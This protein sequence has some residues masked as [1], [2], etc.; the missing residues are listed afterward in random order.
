MSQ[1]DPKELR[2]TLVRA[3]REIERLRKQVAALESAGVPIAIVGVGLRLPGGICDLTGLWRALEAQLDAIGPIPADRWKLDDFYDPDTE[4]A[5]KSY[6]REGGFVTNIDR[7]DP[8]FFGISP[9]EAKSIDPQHRLLLETAWEALEHAGIVPGSLAGTRTGVFVGIG[10]SDYGSLMRDAV[11]GDGYAIMGSHVSFAP[12]RIAFHLGLQGPSIALD[13]ACSSSLVALHLACASLRARESTIA[14]A[15]GA[16]A[17]TDPHTFVQLSRT[18]ALA[19]DGRS[20][21]FSDRADGYGRG[22]GAIVL[23]LERLSDAVASGREVLAVIRGSAVNHDG[24]SSGLTAPNGLAQQAVIRAA[25]SDANLEPN[26]IDYVEC[27]GTGTILGDPIE[28]GALAAVHAKGRTND[29]PLLLGTV[30]SNLGHLE[31]AS[32]LA[33]VAKLI[34]CLRHAKLPASLHALPLNR[35]IEWESLPLAVVTESVSWSAQAQ[36]PRRAAVSS[37]GLSGTNAHVILEG[38]PPPPAPRAR[39]HAVASP[40]PLLLSA[41]SQPALRH[42]AQ[43]LLAH[44][45]AERA[46][47]ALGD[48]AYSLATTR[49]HLEHRV[50]FVSADLEGALATLESIAADGGSRAPI[51]DR[52]RARPL[53]A[54]MFTGQGSQLH[55][56]GGALIDAY[57]VFRDAFEACAKLFDAQLEHDLRAVVRGDEPHAELL[58][59]TAYTQPALFAL[60]VA[61]F[62]LFESWGLTPDLVLGHSIGELAAAHVAGVVSLEHACALVAARG[63]L[64]QALPSGGVMI[65]IEAS[66]A[67]VR[68]QLGRRPGAVDIAGIN[69]P[70]STV[71]AGDDAAARAVAAEFEQLGRA[72]KH[73]TVS[74]AFHSQHMDAML[75]PLEAVAAGL[76]LRPPTLELVSNVTGRLATP[77]QLSSAKYW[78]DHARREVR[79]FDAIRTLETLGTTVVLELGPRGVLTS[80]A[81]GCL[82]PDAAKPM[83]LIASLRGDRPAIE[84]LASSVAELHCHGIALNWS[85]Y[86]EGRGCRRVP[87]P[88]YA[89]ARE[90]HWLDARPPRAGVGSSGRHPLSG[91]RVELPDDGAIHNVELGPAVQRYLADH[92]VFETI[93]V[94][95]AFYLAIMLA[96]GESCWPGRAIELR[97]VEFVRALGFEG[98][99]DRVSLHVRLTPVERDQLAASL[100]SR[101]SE[102]VWTTHANAILRAIEP[103]QLEPSLDL[104]SLEWSA[105]QADFAQMLQTMQIDWGPSWWWLTQTSATTDATVVGRLVAPDQAQIQDA[106]IPGGL[107]DN[108]FALVFWTPGFVYD[109]TPRLPFAVRRMVWSG[110]PTQPHYA[111]LT[112]VENALEQTTSNIGLFDDRGRPLAV[113]EGFVTRSAPPERFLARRP[114][115]DLYTVDHERVAAPGPRAATWT[116]LGAPI[117]GLPGPAAQFDDV[118]ALQLAR[119][120]AGLELGLTLSL[121]DPNATALELTLTTL[122]MLRTW[123]RSTQLAGHRL[124]VIT[125]QAIAA[126]PGDPVEHPAQAS[127][128][129][130]LRTAQTEHPEF[131]LTVVDVDEDPRST[132]ALLSVPDRPQ[133][134]I[135]GGEYLEPKLAAASLGREPLANPLSALAG[136]VLITGVTGALGSIVARHLVHEHGVRHLLGLSRAGARSPGAT[137]LCTELALAGA[138][139]RI[140]ACDVGDR[141]ALE[142]ALATVAP[143]QPLVAVMHIAGALD[144]A[145]IEDLRVEQVERVFAAK[146]DGARHLDE[147]TRA[148]PL[149]AF[150][151]FSSYSGIIGT[152]GQANYAAANTYLDS[153]AAQRR[154]LGL[155]ATSLAWGPWAEGGMAAR[156]GE[157]DRG[158]MRRQGVE[159]FSSADALALLDAAVRHDASVCVP[160]RLDLAALAAA[161][162]EP[163]S[164]LRGL[165]PRPPTSSS[166]A[167][168]LPA[169]LAQLD[170]TR[171]DAATLALVLDATVAVLGLAGASELDPEQPLSELGLDSLMAIELRNRLQRATQLRLPSTLLFDH[172]TPASLRDRLLTE[173]SEVAA[174]VPAAAARSSTQR[175]HTDDDDAIAIVGMACRFPG[176]VQDPE[177]LW[178]LLQDG[179]NATGPMPSNR[180]WD[181][182]ALH[183]PDPR[184]PGKSVTQRGGFLHDAADFDPLFF[185]ISPREAE[186]IDPQQRLLLETSW[187]AMEDA[188]IRPAKLRGSNTGVFV[189]IMYNDYGGRFINDPAALTG[190]VA[191]GSAASVAS[192]RLA[193]VFGLEGPALAVDTACS[194]SLVSTHLAARALRE[195]ECDLALASGVAVMATPGSF[196]EFSRQGAL[197]RDGRCKAFGAAADGVGWAEGAGVLILE[198]LADARANGHTVH[199]IIRGSAINQDGRSQGLTAPNGPAQQRVIEA[200][201]AAAQLSPLDVDA[202]EAHGTGTVLGDPI[203]AQALQ[204]V[205]GRGRPSDAPLWLGSIKSNLGHTQAAAGIAGIIKIVLAMRHQQLPRTLF[206]APA[207][208]HVDWSSSLALLHEPRP[209]T[210]EGRPRRAAVSSFGISGTNAHVILE[211]VDAPVA[212]EAPS[213]APSVVVISGKTDRA[214]RAQARSLRR[215][216]ERHEAASLT[217]MASGLAIARTQF[218][219]RAAFVATTRERALS[220]LE[221]L[222]DDRPD[223]T[224]ALGVVAHRPTLAFMFTGQGAQWLGMG[225]EL[226]ERQPVYRAAF[227]QVAAHLDPQLERPL[228]SIVFAEPGSATAAYLDQTRFTQPALFAVEVALYRLLESWGIT[229]Q[230]VIGH[231]I[232]EL[233]AAHVAG[234]L[235]LAHACQLVAARGRSMQALPTGGAMV[236]IAASESEV[237]AEI[238]RQLATVDIAGING[239]AS[240]VVSGPAQATSAIAEHFEALG[241]RVRRLEVSHAFHSR[242]MDP[243]LD[244]FRRVAESI[245]YAAPQLAVISSLTGALADPDQ[246]RDPAYWVRQVRDPVRFHDGV[247]A[248]AHEGANV[249]LEIGPH[250]V[251]S[252]MARDCLAADSPVSVTASLRRDRS[253]AKCLAETLAQLHCRGVEVDWLPY[254]GR[255]QARL[256]APLPTYAFQR[257]RYWMSPPPPP[258][259]EPAAG[260]LERSLWSEIERGDVGRLAKLAGVEP[261]VID[262]SWLAAMHR[263]RAHAERR[264]TLDSWRYVERWIPARDHVGPNAPAACV[265]IIPTGLELELPVGARTLTLERTSSREQ[266]ATQLRELAAQRPIDNWVS[267]LALDSTPSDHHCALTLTLMHAL[268]DL[269]DAPETASAKLC[270][271]T[272]GAVS[273]RPTD[274]PVDPTQSMIW[275]LSR[276]FALEYPGRWGGLVD[277]PLEPSHEDARWIDAGLA[278]AG[279]DQ[280]AVRDGALIVRRLA[281]VTANS[282]APELELPRVALVT[283]GTGALGAQTARWLAH[284]GTPHLILTSRSGDRA[285]GATQLRS[286]LEALGARVTIARC[287]VANADALAQLLAQL[288]SDGASPDAIFHV[289]GISGEPGPLAELDHAAFA[290]VAAGK[291]VGARN[292]HEQTLALPIRTFVLFGSIAGVW[293]AAQQA[294][295]SAANAYL[296]GLARH[297]TASGL[298][299][300]CVGWGSWAGGGMAEGSAGE[301]LDRLGVRAMDPEVALAGL[302]LSLAEGH[303]AVVIADI[304]WSVLAPLFAMHG[305]RPLFDAID[306]A[307]RATMKLP[308]AQDLRRALE[309]L[310]PAQ[311]HAAGLLDQLMEIAG[312]GLELASASTAS[313]PPPRLTHAQIIPAIIDAARQVLRVPA[314]VLDPGTGLTALGLDSLMALELRTLLDSK[315]ISIPIAE[316][317]RGRSVAELAAIVTDA[318]PT[319]PDVTPAPPVGAWIS[320]DT[321]RPDAQLRLVCFPYAAGGPAVFA[322]WP[323]LLGED[324]EVCVAHLP[325]RGSRLDEPPLRSIDAFAQPLVEAMVPL[326]D[327]PLA[328]FGHCMGSVLM[329]EVA[330]R[331]E[332]EHGASFV[333]VF[334]SG[335]APPGS[336]QSPLLHLLDEAQLMEALGVIGFTNASALLEDRELRTLLLPMLRGD[337]EAVADYSTKYEALTPISSPITVIA[338]LRDAFVAPR[339]IPRW[340]RYTTDTTTLNLIDENHYFVES[341]RAAVVE[342]VQAELF[343]GQRSSARI[344]MIPTDEWASSIRDR[345][346]PSPAASPVVWR[347]P[348]SEN[349]TATLVLLPDIWGTSFPLDNPD[350]VDPRWSLCEVRYPDG[351]DS[352]EVFLDQLLTWF[353][354]AVGHPAVL[355]GHGFGGICAAELAAR[356]G[357]RVDALYIANAIPPGDYGLPFADLLSDDAL[358]RLLALAGHPSSTPAALP[359]IRAG[360]Q[361]GS[362]YPVERRVLVACPITVLRGRRSILFS[363]HTA[364][365]WS[366]ATTGV[367]R[368]VDHDG[369]QFTALDAELLP[370]LRI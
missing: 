26:E 94:P 239:P 247:L 100:H 263:L 329:F 243:M 95:G 286:E 336:Y 85:A 240:T 362:S 202:I 123:L 238:D 210:R 65:S 220:E 81:A 283:G 163:P 298:A 13:T 176:G 353:G 340:A 241:H 351:G 141:E 322:E 303:S 306:E 20:K 200:A 137:E 22:E 68:E 174:T 235:S 120:E 186:A 69:G 160:V 337:F 204:A 45:R 135:R 363:F 42:Q 219:H 19:P 50:A 39:A 1:P 253:D 126:K 17:M 71:I 180:G 131:S 40:V 260:S 51:G 214:L 234:I 121:C 259:P 125:R 215:W 320:V 348:P 294:A 231:S 222:G 291:V 99:D 190:H 184:A 269:G 82:A 333:R 63:R 187:E 108:A 127:V 223:H 361:L 257:S 146:V 107:I 244:E 149:Q 233:A 256:A 161:D 287:D 198:R 297:R 194:S 134:L 193:Y 84:A 354:D 237:Q 216:L 254:V 49:S 295:Y 159:P 47:A 139:L 227:S 21:A 130:L 350:A 325:G 162:A 203:E 225:R 299:A 218:A 102:G 179:R 304:D 334:A 217:D 305:P 116:R 32:G 230:L 61:L 124:V 262:D 90:R 103:P 321:P 201:L 313:S 110:A 2:A 122:A 358:L 168:S 16:A 251:L 36:A 195:R 62:R 328:L 281:R 7:F 129:G 152:A 273:T 255:G 177:Q 189:G 300:T 57:P 172:P 338:A 144:D 117:D 35:H 136:T 341:D 148:R 319:S 151:L 296:E 211:D 38:P 12:G 132:A 261:A 147:L 365:H 55:G 279:E 208:P 67:E 308:S 242:L 316:L 229:P 37:F 93:V 74:H 285:A 23:V 44:L 150:V 48:V 271:I 331:L 89:F 192:G 56:M 145:V 360:V 278:L 109:T 101:D 170:A 314:E 154:G 250:A 34:A 73:L 258:K 293:G 92:R 96:I 309:Q 158:R 344:R 236:A 15:C 205:Y 140:L 352:A 60:E 275:G 191:L 111:A 252:A 226:F 18:R 339:F 330:A 24:A 207:S 318:S 8:G 311:L 183:D 14:L 54:V 366:H 112:A 143:A 346:T 326:C 188:G 312:P 133:L 332:R 87:L 357:D 196:I 327:K 46:S 284:A 33:G 27:H 58:D 370:R 77:A 181:L 248:L 209:W 30:K 75:A 270:V 302:A 113:I 5:G 323:A 249:L 11:D 9:R 367:V 368:F 310:S 343:G 53:L 128:W 213:S 114:V 268:C 70:R 277:L 4:A 142:H 206:A 106:P 359:R 272:R 169:S 307:R 317:L 167:P 98:P 266:L 369:D 28:V 301:A 197:A 31:A 78:A 153:L 86:Y 282:G 355:L 52:V 79:F 199:A 173:L 104:D 290:E 156:L 105:D 10:A 212:D 315:G 185:G 41:R 119:A 115:R 267:I 138:E 276:S 91:V 324:V 59:Q 356:F 72:V 224:T 264:A 246:L 6:A 232:G 25:L 289:A 76:E 83:T 43:Q 342:L 347:R 97:D 118:E 171:R 245:E 280:V 274:E 288:A 3:M 364:A 29:R 175:P 157:R 335:S 64:M 345:P 164:I 166:P 228:G 221:R 292:L 349:T 155:P 88:T 80:M 182:D 178:A 66:E 165:A 265:F